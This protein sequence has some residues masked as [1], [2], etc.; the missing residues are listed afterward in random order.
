MSIE[1]ARPSDESQIIQVAE[2]TGVFSGEELSVL[3]EILG[4]YYHPG[5]NDAYEFVVYRDGSAD[6]VAGFGCYGPIPMA[7]RIWDMYWLGVD[8]AQQGKGIGNLIMKT[9]EEDLAKRGARTIYLETSDSDHY[10]AAR[11]LYERRAYERIAHFPD[12]YAV[13]EGKVIFRKKLN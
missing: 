10:R 4:V 12:Y 8:P 11:N 13:G 2:K 6:S 3:R 7:D 9:V 5:P 1:L